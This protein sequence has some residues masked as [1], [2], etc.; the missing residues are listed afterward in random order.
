MRFMQITIDL[1]PNAGGLDF[2]KD[3]R[4][5]VFINKEIMSLSA[6]PLEVLEII[7]TSMRELA[8]K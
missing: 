4:Y 3:T 6:D 7:E 8:Y 1:R 2:W 5:R